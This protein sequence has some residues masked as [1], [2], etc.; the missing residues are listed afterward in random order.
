MPGIFTVNNSHTVIL[1]SEAV[2]LCTELSKLTE[3]Q[4]LYIILAYDY[5]DS[6]WRRYPLE[7]RKRLSKRKIW[8][9]QEFVP[10]EFANMQLAIDEYKGLIYDIDYEMRDALLSKL[11][12]LDHNLIIETDTSKINLILRS[13][14]ILKAR[15]DELD[16]KIDIKQEAIKLKSSKKLSYIE[17]FMRNREQYNIKMAE[18]MRLKEEAD[19]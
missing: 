12:T 16:I 7:D 15:L 13:Q 17:M 5:L 14:D 2:K 4:V 6:P 10:E 18:V 19:A 11:K 8:G 9:D 3:E 1:S